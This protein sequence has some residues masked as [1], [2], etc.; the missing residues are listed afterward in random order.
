MKIRELNNKLRDSIDEYLNM[1]VAGKTFSCP[2]FL[3][4]FQFVLHELLKKAVIPKEKEAQIHE[5]YKNREVAYGWY[6]GKGTPKEIR[7]AI[8][9]LA[10]IDKLNLETITPEGL[11]NFMQL[12]G[13]GIDCSGF[14]YNILRITLSKF[15]YFD[16]LKNSLNWQDPSEKRVSKANVAT[17]TGNASYNIKP[18]EIRPLDLILINK[19]EQWTHIAVITRNLDDNL[20]V[21][22]S[23][24]TVN[25][26]GV[27]LYPMEIVDNTPKFCFKPEIGE[28]WEKRFRKG[29][30]EFR[31]LK[32]LEKVA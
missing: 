22:Q 11:R 27:S 4:H 9:K 10:K 6:R 32:C 25:P 7:D 3:N 13:I 2:Y 8:T 26:T 5:M 23:A 12:Y 29:E 24:N 31:R 28:T 14:A 18:R 1:N 16:K 15:N 20:Q 30:L 21:A 17:F 19:N